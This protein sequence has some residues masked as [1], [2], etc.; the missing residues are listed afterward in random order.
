MKNYPYSF[1]LI[2]RRSLVND[3]T[4]IICKLTLDYLF[5][6]KIVIT[7]TQFNASYSCTLLQ[8]NIIFCIKE[9]VCLKES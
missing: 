8:F 7:M 4:T 9:V 6:F 5:K 2:S 1:L 3:T